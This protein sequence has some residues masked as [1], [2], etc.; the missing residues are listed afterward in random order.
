MNRDELLVDSLRDRHSRDDSDIYAQ[1]VAFV[2][3]ELEECE[4]NTHSR[5]SALTADALYSQMLEMSPPPGQKA[6]KLIAASELD[7]IRRGQSDAVEYIRYMLSRP[8]GGREASWFAAR[9]VYDVL[10]DEIG[11]LGR[12]LQA[13]RTF[14]T[15]D[16]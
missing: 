11:R 9:R 2:L 15:R 16:K 12:E 13:A 3:S 5:L 8:D 14:F 6:S 10:I 1:A 7:D 4:A